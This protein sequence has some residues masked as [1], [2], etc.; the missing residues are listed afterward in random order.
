[1]SDIDG[2]FTL[3]ALVPW[4]WPYMLFIWFD[5]D[6]PLDQQKTA[7]VLYMYAAAAAL[8]ASVLSAGVT[9]AA[10]SLDA[11]A[12]HSRRRRCHWQ[13]RHPGRHRHESEPL[14]TCKKSSSHGSVPGA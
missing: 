13:R 2:A 1:M 11:A 4:L 12:T 10:A 5:V 14:S 3:L 6:V 8:A 7:G 9:L